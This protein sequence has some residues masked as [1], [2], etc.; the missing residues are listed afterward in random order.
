[1]VEVYGNLD[2]YYHEKLIDWFRNSEYSD[3][4]LFFEFKNPRDDQSPFYQSQIDLLV[5][6][7]NQKGIWLVEIKNKKFT[8]VSVNGIWE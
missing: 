6:R 3:A 5:L 7:P 4:F 1:M 8:K 2:K